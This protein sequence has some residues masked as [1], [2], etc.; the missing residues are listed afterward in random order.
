MI[1]P[2]VIIALTVLIGTLL[3]LRYAYNNKPASSENRPDNKEI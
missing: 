3:Y 2:N 1:D